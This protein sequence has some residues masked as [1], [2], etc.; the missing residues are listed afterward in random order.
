MTDDL[1]AM[2]VYAI[3]TRWPCT[4]RAFIDLGLHCV[5]C[6]IGNFHTVADAISAHGDHA[7]GLLAAIRLSISQD[8]SNPADQAEPHPRSAIDYGGP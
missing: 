1:N 4:M 6:P 5:G 7:V 8:G 2:S 3:M